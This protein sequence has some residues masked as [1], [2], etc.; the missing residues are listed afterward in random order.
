M[1]ATVP[2]AIAAVG[3]PGVMHRRQVNAYQVDAC[4]VDAWLVDAWLVDR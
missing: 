3:E 2:H 4:Q 1:G